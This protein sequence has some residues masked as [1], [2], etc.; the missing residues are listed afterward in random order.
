MK[1]IF[2]GLSVILTSFVFAQEKEVIL[3]KATQ[4]EIA[5]HFLPEKE[6][7]GAKVLGY[8]QDGEIEVLRESNSHLTCVAD[9]PGKEG[10][11]YICYFNKLEDFMQRG[12][13]LKKEGKSSKEVRE[14]RQREIET[15]AL[16]F[17]EGQ[18]ILYI[19][20]GKEEN[21]DVKTGS[22]IDGKLRYVVYTPYA[23]QLSTGLPLSP[24]APGMP[25]LM[26]PGTHRAHIMITP[27]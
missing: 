22:V 9:D 25:W 8:S 6:K 10:L 12:R 18:S 16:L 11:E 7:E 19:F 20:T 17:P 13:D 5:T 21:I 27:S 1:N 15:G 26:D 4:I 24:S 2:I 23:T 14:I 3:D